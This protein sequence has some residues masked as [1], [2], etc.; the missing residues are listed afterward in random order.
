MPTT[1]TTTTIHPPVHGCIYAIRLGPTF[2]FENW[3]FIVSVILLYFRFAAFIASPTVHRTTPC[4]DA[5][6]RHARR[7]LVGAGAGWIIFMCA[8]QREWGNL[9]ILTEIIIS[10]ISGK[11]GRTFNIFEDT[12]RRRERE[13]EGVVEF[14]CSHEMAHMLHS[15]QCTHSRNV[16]IEKRRRK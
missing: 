14:I 2:Y 8:A 15:A 12:R 13:R 1:T 6:H 3:L 5:G 16:E 4:E 9:I 7:T 10:Q 11:T